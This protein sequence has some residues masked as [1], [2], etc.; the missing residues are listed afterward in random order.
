MTSE[1]DVVSH[2]YVEKVNPVPDDGV[3]GDGDGSKL[4][5]ARAREGQETEH[6]QTLFQAM[7]AYPMAI[8]WSFFVSMCIIME[9]Y[10]TILYAN[11]FS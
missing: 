4:L 5:E 8:F 3:P 1:K 10:D 2:D 7:K 9:G 6:V 11:S